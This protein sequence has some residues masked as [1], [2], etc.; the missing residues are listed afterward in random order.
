MKIRRNILL[1]L[2]I[3]GSELF[4]QAAGTMAPDFT[5]ATLNHGSISLSQYRGRV[6]YLFFFGWD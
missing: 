1:I 3:L 2:V 4:A 5:H 6:V